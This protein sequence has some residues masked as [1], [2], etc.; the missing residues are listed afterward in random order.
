MQAGESG[1]ANAQSPKSAQPPKSSSKTHN[2]GKVFL[3]VPFAEKDAAKGLGARWDATQ[4]KWYVPQGVD[5][6]QFGRWM[7]DGGR[8]SGR[9]LSDI[10]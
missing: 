6:D 10:N 9:P 3:N 5:V 8:L 7:P 1:S 2:Q 4:K